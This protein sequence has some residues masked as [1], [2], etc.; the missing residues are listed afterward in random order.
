MA[1]P[2]VQCDAFTDKPFAGN[3]VA[4]VVTPTAQEDTWMQQ[5]AA[6]MNLSETAFLV[7]RSHDP[8]QAGSISSLQCSLPTC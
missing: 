6:E 1:I 7:P 8:V 4:V 3:P 2:I 5:V